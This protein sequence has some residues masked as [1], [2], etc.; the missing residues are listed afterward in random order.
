MIIIL[1]IVYFNSH[2]NSS[3][4]YRVSSYYFSKLFG[5]L[6]PLRLLP[7]PIFVVIAYW[8]IGNVLVMCNIQNTNNVLACNLG[9]AQEFLNGLR[10]T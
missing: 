5:D 8:M 10:L 3:G 4:Y 2:E 7:I 1:Y 6:I 9:S